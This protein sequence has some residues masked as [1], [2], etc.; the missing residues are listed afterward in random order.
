MIANTFV[1]LNQ[2]LAEEAVN[3]AHEHHNKPALVGIS[4]FVTLTVLMLIT[5]QFNR[6]K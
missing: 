1:V 2:I 6:G 3:T 5:L 4:V